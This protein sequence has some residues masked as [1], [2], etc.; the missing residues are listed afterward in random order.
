MKNVLIICSYYPPSRAVGAIRPAKFAKYLPEF[1]WQPI[2]LTL[3]A[4]QPAEDVPEESAP[5]PVYT[6]PA[7]TLNA[8]YTLGRQLFP[9]QAIHR[10]GKSDP[11]QRESSFASRAENIDNWLFIPDKLVTWLPFA[12]S[13]GLRIASAH[14]IQAILSTSPYPT[15]HLVAKR[16]SQR[17]ACPWVA[18]FRDPWLTNPFNHYPTALHKKAHAVLEGKVIRSAN[19]V[20]TISE[21]ICQDFIERYPDQSRSKFK[22]VYNGY[23]SADFLGLEVRRAS[24]DKVHIV[25]SGSFYGGRDPLTFLQAVSLFTSSDLKTIK[26][27]FLGRGIQPLQPVINELGLGETVLLQEFLPYRKSLQ[28]LKDA[29]ILLLIPGPGKGTL[30]TKVYEYLGVGKYILALAPSSNSAMTSLLK[31]AN[32]G[33]VVDPDSPE[34]IFKRLS[35]LIQAVRSGSK[36]EPNRQF[37]EQFDRREL[38]R[39]LAQILDESTQ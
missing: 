26:V 10:S 33:L 19:Q 37:I 34:E 25:H 5:I 28:F 17:L 32:L 21:P 2:I 1:G 13:K 14:R 7:P 15:C 12:A 20:V 18:D 22:I 6:V 29:D 9:R 3:P 11:A 24:Q 16:L 4:T 36:P 30:T 35:Q 27:T 8:L 39:R 38:T 31:K 23:D